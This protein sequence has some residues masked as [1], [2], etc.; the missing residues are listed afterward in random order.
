MASRARSAFDEHRSRAE[1]VDVG[2][3]ARELEL[4]RLLS[5]APVKVIKYLL[6][7]IVNKTFGLR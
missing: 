4:V 6:F 7:T 2:F 5:R 3:D 1:K